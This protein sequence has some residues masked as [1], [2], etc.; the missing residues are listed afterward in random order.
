MENATLLAK[1]VQVYVSRVLEEM[2]PNNG[3]VSF[4]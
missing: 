3:I 1:R 4:H 2:A